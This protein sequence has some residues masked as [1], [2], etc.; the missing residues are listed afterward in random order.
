MITPE[1]IE[2][3]NRELAKLAGYYIIEIE[4][5]FAYRIQNKCSD[6]DENQEYW[7]HDTRVNGGSIDLDRAWEL[8]FEDIGKYVN[9]NTDDPLGGDLNALAL[10]AMKLRLLVTLFWSSGAA[11]VHIHDTWTIYKDKPA[12]A[13]ALAILETI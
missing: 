6:N 1:N 12:H 4:R 3:V 10:L 11:S 7:G 2:Q 5:G 9:L 13:L 8:L